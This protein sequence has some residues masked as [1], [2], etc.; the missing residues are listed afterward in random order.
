MKLPWWISPAGVS[1][2]LMLPVLLLIWF[3]GESNLPGLTLRGIAFLDATYL[4]LGASVLLVM[5]VSAW[6]GSQIDVGRAQA[7]AP[8][9]AAWERAALLVGG[10]ALVAYLIFFK[11]FVA[12]PLLLIQTLMG[13]YRP[14][15]TNM[16]LTAGVTSFQNFGPVFFSLYAYLAI[17]RQAPVS[18]WLHA[19]FAVLIVLTALRVYAWSE[20]LALV[21]AAV[22]L[23]LSVAVRLAQS[24]SQLSRW[25]ARGGPFVAFPLFIVYFGVA[26]YFRSW[27]SATYY[28][29]SSFWEFSVGRLASYYYTSLNNGAGILATSEWPDYRFA[30]TLEWLHR[31]PFVG[32]WFSAYM[33]L[34]A[35]GTGQF[36]SKFGDP[37]FNNPSGIYAVIFDLGLPLGFVYFAMLGIAAGIAYRAFRA[38]SFGG[39]LCYPLLFLTFLEVFRYPYLGASRGFAWALGIAVAYLVLRTPRTATAG[40]SGLREVP[41]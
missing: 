18:R 3:L 14:N 12:N 38:G 28:G 6:I 4:A 11:D 22:P 19:M 35:K 40:S 41:A 1:A 2:G 27:Q 10:I 9:I 29:R 24:R 7:A 5:S 25:I 34:R 8:E 23:G 31:A 16:A 30:Y 37:E 39:V 26:E 17:V 36:L 32:Q 21:E 33:D 13:D 20:R 15:R